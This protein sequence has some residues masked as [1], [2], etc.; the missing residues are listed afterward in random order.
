MEIP[1]KIIKL[2]SEVYY[3]IRK[4]VLDAGFENS[5]YLDEVTEVIDLHGLAVSNEKESST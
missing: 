1:Y 2:P 5:I 4:A 3:E